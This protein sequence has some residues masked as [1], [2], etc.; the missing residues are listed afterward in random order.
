MSVIQKVLAAVEDLLLGQGTVT[1]ERNGAVYTVNKINAD[2]IPYAN[3]PDDTDFVSVKDQMDKVLWAKGTYDFSSNGGAVQ[4]HNIFSIPDNAYL[5]ETWYE[6]V[7]APTSAGLATIAM[8]VQSDDETGILASTA[9]DDEAFSVG[10]HDTLVFPRAANF[11][12]KTTAS[13]SIIMT[14]GT[15]ALT[16][17]K[18]YFWSKYIVSE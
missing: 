16:A 10:P 11:T 6:V 13:R 4:D 2:K 8:G 15:A 14:I 12:T 9:F 1:Q 17:G 3:E 7:T 5:V 18:I